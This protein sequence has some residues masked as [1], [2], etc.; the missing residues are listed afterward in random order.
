MKKSSEKREKKRKKKVSQSK[1]KSFHS[2]QGYVFVFVIKK[3][4]PNFFRTLFVTFEFTLHVYLFNE[5][6]IQED[7]FFRSYFA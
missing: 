4:N 3:K 1:F 6:Q 7:R 2:H 5:I